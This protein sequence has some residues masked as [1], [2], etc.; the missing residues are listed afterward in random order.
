MIEKFIPSFIIKFFLF[1]FVF[2]LI[3]LA[4]MIYHAISTAMSGT[5]YCFFFCSS[6][7]AIYFRPYLF[8]ISCQISSSL[9]LYFCSYITISKN[10]FTPKLD[11]YDIISDSYQFVPHIVLPEVLECIFYSVMLTI[12]TSNY[13]FFLPLLVAKYPVPE[14]WLFLYIQLA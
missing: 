5:I 12:N 10:Y 8:F 7:F 6:T 4:N 9:R 1:S 3:V 14:T 2:V 13:L 11:N